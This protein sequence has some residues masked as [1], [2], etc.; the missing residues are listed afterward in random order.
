MLKRCIK[1]RV[2]YDITQVNDRENIG[3]L[4]IEKN[5]SNTVMKAIDDDC[6]ENA[7]L[8]FKYLFMH[9]KVT[10]LNRSLNCG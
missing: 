6:E 4:A 9:W 10:G 3:L 7:L 1:S 8:H 5:I 2:N